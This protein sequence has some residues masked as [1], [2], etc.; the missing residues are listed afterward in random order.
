MIRQSGPHRLSADGVK[1]F[2]MGFLT[3][4][5]ELALIRYLA[6]NI[7]NLIGATLGGVAEY[8]S[9]LFGYQFLALVVVF[10]Y[11]IVCVMLYFGM[12]T[13]RPGT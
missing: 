13:A 10:C 5:L 9:M 7:W 3:L 11:G 12:R 4:F 8:F 1:L 6:G 2:S